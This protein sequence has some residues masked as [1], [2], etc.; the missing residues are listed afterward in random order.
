MWIL[1]FQGGH[2]AAQE[3]CFALLKWTLVSPVITKIYSFIAMEPLRG[4]LFFNRIIATAGLLLR[5]IVNIQ[6]RVFV[7]VKL[8]RNA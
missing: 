8:A 6:Q 2:I 5:I 1:M 3:S 7:A 4:A